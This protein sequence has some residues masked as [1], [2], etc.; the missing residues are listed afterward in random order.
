MHMDPYDYFIAVRM[1][2]LAPVFSITAIVSLAIG[3]GANTAIFTAAN[4]IFLAPGH[5]RR[6]GHG[7]PR[8]HRSNAGG[9][10]IRH[11]CLYLT[12]TDLRDRVSAFSGE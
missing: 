2:A 4:A 11:G 7:P 6:G 10:W 9:P 3:I 8:G 1:L 12:Y 5:G